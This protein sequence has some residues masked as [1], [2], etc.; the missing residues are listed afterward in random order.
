MKI[1]IGIGM[2]IVINQSLLL[3]DH[4]KCYTFRKALQN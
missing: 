1:I 4:F 2:E 3:L